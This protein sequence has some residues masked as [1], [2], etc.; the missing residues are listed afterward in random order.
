MQL[1]LNT[2][3]GRK[4]RPGCPKLMPRWIGPYKVLE[5]VGN[6]ACRLDLPLEFK[7]HPV[8]HVSLLQPWTGSGRVQPPTPRL[9]VGGN[10][11]WTIDRTL[12]HR[13]GKRKDFVEL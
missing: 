9:L 4:R 2:K 1:M 5:R 11:A 12:D 6:V 3:H 8:F 10:L 7:M 13:A